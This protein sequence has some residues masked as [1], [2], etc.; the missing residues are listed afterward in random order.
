[1]ITPSPGSVRVVAPA[2]LHLGFLDP[3]ATLGRRFGSLGLALQ[4]LA[5]EVLAVAAEVVSAS[6]EETQRAHELAA[7]AVSAFEL[8]GAASIHVERAIPGHAGLGSG[9][10]LALAIGAAM[11]RLHGREVAAGTLG[12]VLGR[13]RRSG[14]GIGVFE[15]GGL[16]VDA[17]HGALTS[18]PPL[19]ARLVFPDWPVIL[20]F[21]H[22]A[23]GLS[24]G[25]E[26]QAFAALEPLARHH[27]AHLCH[28][29]LMRLLPA[30]VERDFAPFAASLGEIQAV[31][32]DHFARVQGG[33]YT[34]AAVARVIDYLVREHGLAGVGQSSWG[35]TAFAFVDSAE[36]ATRVVEALRREFAGAG[37][38]EFRV[39]RARNEGATLNVERVLPARRR[40][41]A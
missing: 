30:V 4:D 16:V 11:T 40:A 25:A 32:G 9:T 36:H 14:I 23:Q 26:V 8:P 6:G 41:G 5:T 35:P 20:V 28:L 38:L 18:T 15:H 19:L 7:R 34:S 29:T 31:V 37:G 24:G 33:R 12:A 1:M 39:A 27:A 17:G 22:A 2:R 3:S 13:G 10:Q 21:D